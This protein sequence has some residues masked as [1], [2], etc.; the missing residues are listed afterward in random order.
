M[1]E[2]NTD[3]IFL[4]SL[5]HHHS[6]ETMFFNAFL[7]IVTDDVFFEYFEKFGKIVDSVV[8]YDRLT[9]RSRGFGFVTFEDNVSFWASYI[10]LISYHE[11]LHYAHIYIY[12]HCKLCSLDCSTFCD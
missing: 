2:P 8:M 9:K 11:F 6:A 10:P 1:R 12:I 3:G 7:H 5:V 4:S